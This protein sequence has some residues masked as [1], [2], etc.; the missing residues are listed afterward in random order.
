MAY[1][2][3]YKTRLCTTGNRQTAGIHVN[4]SDLYVPVL[5]AHE[6]RQLIAIAS[7]LG[8]KYD[9]TQAFLYG[10]VDQDLYELASD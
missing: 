10:D 8:E 6:V 2:S 4:Q 7:Q 1:S 9:T 3:K 5:K